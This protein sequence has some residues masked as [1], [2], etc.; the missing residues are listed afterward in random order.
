[1]KKITFTLFCLLILWGCKKDSKSEIIQVN[2][3]VPANTTYSLQIKNANNDID[4]PNGA[5]NNSFTLNASSGDKIPIVYEF[6]TQQKPYGQGTITFT[7]N[8]KTLLLI[9]GGAGT[10]TLSIP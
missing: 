7:Y 5:S 1:M 2:V 3:A 8:S 10:Q 4:I 6:A 9:N